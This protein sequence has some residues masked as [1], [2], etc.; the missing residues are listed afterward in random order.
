MKKKLSRRAITLAVVVAIFFSLGISTADAK[1]VRKTDNFIMLT[2]HSGS[3]Y[4]KHSVSKTVKAKMVKDFLTK[5][6]PEI[7]ELGYNGALVRFAPEK[8]A[9]GPETF[10]QTNFASAVEGQ[11]I[12]GRIFGNFTPLG[13]SM[14]ELEDMI[15]GF[16]GKTTLIILSDGCSNKGVNPITAATTLAAKFPQLCFVTVSFA[17]NLKCDRRLRKIQEVSSCG[18]YNGWA[19]STNPQAMDQFVKDVFYTEE[20]AMVQVKKAAPAAAVAKQVR[21]SLSFSQIMVHF[22]FDKSNILPQWA[23]VLDGVAAEMAGAEETRLMLKGHTD[24]IGSN[25]YNQKLSE[26]RSQAVWNYLVDHGVVPE[27]LESASFGEKDP[28]E[29]NKTKAGRAYNRRVEVSV[30]ED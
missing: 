30:I 7:P 15:A 23:E 13:P 22:D 27:R 18:A 21:K 11:P 5:A 12:T 4:L 29:T 28:G 3:M 20:M 10:S 2:D 9:V 16:S 14:L 8:I 1:L 26:R 17:D 19:L 6:V 25:G 24:S